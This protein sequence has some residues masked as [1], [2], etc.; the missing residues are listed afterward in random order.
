MAGTSF[1]EGSHIIGGDLTYKRLSGND[2]EITLKIYRDWL[3]MA[4][5]DPNITFGVFEQNTHLLI[6]STLTP[7]DT[8]Y[9]VPLSMPGT[10][11]APPPNV[12]VE[13]GIYIDTVSLTY[14]CSFL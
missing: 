7:L 1:S 2:F 9:L 11:C 3:G 12:I 10:T 5:L 8:S 13:A 4:P 14:Q 6:D